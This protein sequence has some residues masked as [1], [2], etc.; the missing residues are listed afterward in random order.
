MQPKLLRSNVTHMCLNKNCFYDQAIL[1]F[2]DLV[3][4]HLWNSEIEDLD[5]IPHCPSCDEVLWREIDVP[6]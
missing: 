2:D 5:L 4:K 3:W 1:D 6:S